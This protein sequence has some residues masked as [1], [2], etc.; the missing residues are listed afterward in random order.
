MRP[1]TDSAPETRLRLLLLEAGCPEPEV[2]GIVPTSRGAFHGDLVFRDQRVIVEYDGEQ[3]R[4]DD[5]QYSI[6]G[7]RLD[8]IMAA[9]WRVI[10]VDK[11]LI[12]RREE[13]VAR[14]LIALAG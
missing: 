13:L 6:D 10:R 11:R 8:A 2:N 4:T 1:G 14:I 5:R 3:H 9:G 7:D 12:R